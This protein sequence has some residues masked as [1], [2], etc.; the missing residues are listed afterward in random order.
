MFA[1]VE[2]DNDDVLVLVDGEVTLA[3]LEPEL[4][5]RIGKFSPSL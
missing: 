3:E 5:E 4:L 2:A 1:E